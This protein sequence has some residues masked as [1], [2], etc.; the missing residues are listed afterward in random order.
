[1]SEYL[2]LETVSELEA[3]AE[4]HT[5][6]DRRAAL[7]LEAYLALEDKLIDAGEHQTRRVKDVKP[8]H[9]PACSTCHLCPRHCHIQ[10]GGG[11]FTAS[12]VA[13]RRPGGI[14][15]EVTE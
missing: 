14:A 5:E 8:R 7:E 10:H 9:G 15:R 6:E 13:C 4:T 12:C 2:R 3:D 11:R 1:M